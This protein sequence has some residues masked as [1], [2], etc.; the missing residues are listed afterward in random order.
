[1]PP[2]LKSWL[3]FLLLPFLA[4]MSG[5]LP[6]SPQTQPAPQAQASPAPQAQDESVEQFR[7]E[8]EEGVK[9]LL[10][11]QIEAWNHGNLEG[12]M[13]GYWHSP[14]LDFFS[15]ANITKGWDSTLQRYQ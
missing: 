8:A 10:V 4:T 14:D 1:M 13:Q 11:S 6:Q 2:M 7:A 12:F 15:G 3:L 5:G 9:H